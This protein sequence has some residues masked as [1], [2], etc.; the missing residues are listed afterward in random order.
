M[1]DDKNVN[2]IKD[3]FEAENDKASVIDRALYKEL[4]ASGPALSAGFSEKVM[5]QVHSVSTE[6]RLGKGF[7]KRDQ[8]GLEWLW[9]SFVF[10]ASVVVLG[11][12]LRPYVD[13]GPILD[14]LNM[15]SFALLNSLIQ[16][17]GI[18]LLEVQFFLQAALALVCIFW[19][20]RKL[21]SRTA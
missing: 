12:G 2:S 11:I 9:L 16:S 21:G 7:D 19:L 17:L 4:G 20:D 6:Q 10:V 18:W 3:R 5:K 8:Q 14:S 15:E 1:K 13:S